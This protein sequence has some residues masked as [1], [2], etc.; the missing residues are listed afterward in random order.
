[1][2]NL[3]L[4]R[5]SGL[6]EEQVIETIV[7][8]FQISSKELDNFTIL[9]GQIDSYEYE[10]D[11]YFLLR[12]NNTELYYEVI[13]SHCSCYGFEEQWKPVLI[14]K[15]YLLSDFYSRRHKPEIVSFLKEMLA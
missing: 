1:M 13:G 12:E 11:A 14:T 10:E 2:K 6:T 9:I 8:E 15:D 7:K 4:D 3:F 5:M